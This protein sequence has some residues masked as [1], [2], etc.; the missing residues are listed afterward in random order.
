MIKHRVSRAIKMV[1]FVLIASVV[2][3]FIVE[4]LWNWLTPALFGWHAITFLQAL[5]LFLLSKILFGG[6]HRGG[7]RGRWGRHMGERWERHRGERWQQMTPEEREKFR[8]DLRGCV[9]GFARGPEHGPEHGSEHE[10]RRQEAP[11]ATS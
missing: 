9:R 5:G 8:S 11:N 1:L 10:P 4:H 3:G 2:C 6:F 7:P